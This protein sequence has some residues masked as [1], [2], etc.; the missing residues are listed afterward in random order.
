MNGITD[1]DE[2]LE[3]LWQLRERGASGVGELQ[4]SLGEHFQ[5]LVQFAFGDD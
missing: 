3:R 5:P 2:M 1:R 4:A